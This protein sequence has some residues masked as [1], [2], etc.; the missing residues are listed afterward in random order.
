MH[1]ENKDIK[2]YLSKGVGTTEIKARNAQGVT[3]Q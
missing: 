2:G 1:P 3:R